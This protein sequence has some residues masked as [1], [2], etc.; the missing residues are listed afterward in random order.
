M[1][2]FPALSLCLLFCLV[3]LASCQQSKV[4][5]NPEKRFDVRGKITEVMK[6]DKRIKLNHE[7]IKSADGKVFMDAMTMPFNVRDAQSLD[8][9]NIGDQI[10]A[11]YVVNENTSL[12]W[13][14]N[15]TLVNNP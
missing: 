10:T 13:L 8:K 11:I 12:S 15:I 1:K 2:T 6:A 9:L 14:E 7:A 3:A 5:A 4:S